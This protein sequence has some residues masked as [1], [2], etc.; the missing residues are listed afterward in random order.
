MSKRCVLHS[1]VV[2]SKLVNFKA[3]L[4]ASQVAPGVKNQSANAG[5]V[6]DSGW[7]P[8]L[9]RSPGGGHGYSILAWRIPWT[10]ESGTLQPIGSRRVGHDSARMQGCFVLK[11]QWWHSWKEFTFFP[12]FFFFFKFILAALGL[13]CIEQLYLPSGMWDL[14]SQIRNRTYVLCSGGLLTTGPSGKSFLGVYIT[15]IKVCRQV[16]CW[17]R[18]CYNTLFNMEKEMY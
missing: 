2:A 13:H 4:W 12:V 11:R 1:H 17:M 3:V 9:G 14:S 16:S 7:I 5:D 6:R 15:L 8:G 10:E 18:V